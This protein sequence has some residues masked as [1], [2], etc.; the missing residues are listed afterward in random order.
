MQ[1]RYTYKIGPVITGK[2]A[3]LN[4]NVGERVEAGQLLGE[5]D[6]VDIAQRLQAQEAAIRSSEAVVLQATAKEDYAKSQARRYE[7]LILTRGTSEE[8]LLS[9]RQEL[10]IASA[11]LSASISEMA[12]LRAERDALLS[13]LKN[14]NL[15][16][17]ADGLVAARN[18]EPGSTVTAGQTVIEIIDPDS[19]WINAR[20]DQHSAE[21]LAAGLPAEITLRSRQ[22][23][24]LAGSVLWVEP[25]ADAVT[26]EMLAKIVFATTPTPLPSIGELAQIRLRLPALAETPTVLNAAIRTLNGQRGVWK[27]TQDGILFV[28]VVLGRTD[29]DGY[30]QVLEGLQVGD[31]V[32][33]YSDKT[34]KADSRIHI[35]GSL[36]GTSR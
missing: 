32:V 1:A 18:A 27:L 8:T 4:V 23:Q 30:V 20:F 12:R 34:L 28:P 22:S 6:A 36:T 31:Q 24:T 11:T 21:G 15:I 3:S 33:L 16:A 35:T 14:L 2:I 7:Q 26:E 5:M 29:L 17:F 19:L 9:K 25:K 10:A 13:Q